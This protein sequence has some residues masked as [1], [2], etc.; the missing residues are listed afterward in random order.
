MSWPRAAAARQISSSASDEN[1]S[2]GRSWAKQRGA[3]GVARDASSP[4]RRIISGARFESRVFAAGAGAG[5]RHERLVV[6]GEPRDDAPTSSTPAGRDRRRRAR[7]RARARDPSSWAARRSG[8]GSKGE[9]VAAVLAAAGSPLATARSIRRSAAKPGQR[10]T[11]GRARARC[12]RR[13][14]RRAAG[15]SDPIGCSAAPQAT[16][17]TTGSA[18]AGTCQCQSTCACASTQAVPTAAPASAADGCL[19]RRSRPARPIAPT[20]LPSSRPGQAERRRELLQLPVGL[21]GHL[22]AVPSAQVG[23]PEAARAVAGQR[24]RREVAAPRPSRSPSGWTRPRAG[25]ARRRPRR[26]PS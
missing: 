6:A 24:P 8:A 3:V 22:A 9:S 16:S 7:P 14:G 25:A 5:A 26:R 11:A 23:R 17:A 12:R 19:R 20:A 15:S 18:T 1:S 21:C 2:S 13:C 4:G 10:P